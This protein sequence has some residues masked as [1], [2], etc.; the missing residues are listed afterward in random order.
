MKET[1]VELMNFQL[2]YLNQ[3]VENI[4]DERLY[5]KQLEG[6]NSA[7]WILGHIC[8]EADDVISRLA[9]NG[10]FGELPPTWQKWFRNAWG[11]I[12]ELEGLPAKEELVNT[13]NRRYEA[14]GK[15]YLKLSDDQRMA[16]HPSKFLRDILTTTDA[17]FA[18]HL[19]THIAMHCGNI[20]VWKKLIGLPVNGF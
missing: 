20:V 18:H 10:A 15:A 14:L 12:E 13:L 1:T 3:L 9:S 11:K 8:V 2:R 5:E 19:T 17:W 16:E 4:P 7:G 6:F